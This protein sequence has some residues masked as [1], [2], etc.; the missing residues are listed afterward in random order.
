M[1]RSLNCCNFSI[2]MFCFSHS[3]DVLFVCFP[4]RLFLRAVILRLTQFDDY[5]TPPMGVVS[6]FMRVARESSGLVAVHCKVR[7][8]PSSIAKAWIISSHLSR[9]GESGTWLKQFHTQM[10]VSDRRC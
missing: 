4:P 1:N 3:H 9:N 7:I 5:G 8:A 6:E 2:T 10:P